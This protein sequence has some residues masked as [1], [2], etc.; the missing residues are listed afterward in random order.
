MRRE[1]R[2]DDTE[3]D[4]TFAFGGMGG[5]VGGGAG[6]SSKIPVPQKIR[7]DHRSKDRGERSAYRE[8][9]KEITELRATNANKEAEVRA[10]ASR[11]GKWGRKVAAE[12]KR[13]TCVHE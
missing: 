12:W 4:A 13:D 11:W 6:G 5:D 9:R 2:G 10:G 8:A 1:A 3:T 7:S